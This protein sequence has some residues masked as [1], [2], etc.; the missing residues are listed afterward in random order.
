MA[1]S[2]A[3]D[4]RSSCVAQ[5][6]RIANVVIIISR[7]IG[8]PFLDRSFID[9]PYSDRPREDEAENHSLI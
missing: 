3:S 9:R 1:V 7:F 5:E 8:L 6:A 2:F 4:R